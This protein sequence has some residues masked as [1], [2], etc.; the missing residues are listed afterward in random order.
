MLFTQL[1]FL[2]ARLKANNSFT[3][4]LSS[5]VLH[6][7]G[8]EPPP[9]LEPAPVALSAAAAP[10][11]LGHDDAARRRQVRRPTRHLPP[12]ARRLRTGTR[13]TAFKRLLLGCVVIPPLAKAFC[14]GSG[15]KVAEPDFIPEI[16]S[17][18]TILCAIMQ[19]ATAKVDTVYSSGCR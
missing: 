4:V 13:V 3:V 11:D 19:N 17:F 12:R 15:C 18:L 10:V 16:E 2:S 9:H 14:T 7:D 1:S 8:A 6:L 5:L